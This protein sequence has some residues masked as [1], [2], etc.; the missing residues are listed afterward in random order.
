MDDTIQDL[1]RNLEDAKSG[2]PP[3]LGMEEGGEQMLGMVKDLMGDLLSEEV[4]YEP[5]KDL[6][7]RYPK[8]L[9]EE[10]LSGEDRKR[11]LL[12]L[13]TLLLYS[14]QTTLGP[15]WP[16]QTVSPIF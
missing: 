10:E 13:F 1:N 16:Y 3:L 4:L 12:L 6:C 9:D 8:Y 7:L 2:G 15:Q 11:Y 14:G 5:M